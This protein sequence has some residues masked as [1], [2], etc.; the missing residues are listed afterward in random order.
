MTARWAVRAATGLPAGSCRAATEGLPFTI[1]PSRQSLR[2]AATSLYTREAGNPSVTASRATFPIGEGSPV[3]AWGKSMRAVDNRPCGQV[4]L[5]RRGRPPG[6]P[7]GGALPL[8][9]GPGEKE[10]GSRAGKDACPYERNRAVWICGYVCRRRV[11][12]LPI[13]AQPTWVQPG[14]RMSAV[15]RPAS[16]VSDT[17]R[18]MQS[19]SRGMSKL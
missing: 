2:P 6:L 10:P 12:W 17:A 8:S 14:D 13:S 9:P 11:I 15:R 1:P 16:R 7:G 5:H 4:R 3:G 19:A 18:S